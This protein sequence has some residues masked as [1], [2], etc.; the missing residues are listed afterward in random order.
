[1]LKHISELDM[2]GAKKEKMF[3]TG[4]HS[5]GITRIFVNCQKSTFTKGIVK[6]V[7]GI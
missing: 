2:G 5:N 4:K 7:I 1:M 6:P 3:L